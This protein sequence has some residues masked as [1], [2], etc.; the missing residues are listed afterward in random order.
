MTGDVVQIRRDISEQVAA[1]VAST[2]PYLIG[3][4]HHSPVLAA[5]VPALLDGFGPQVVVVEFPADFQS[6]IEH[7][8]D[9]RLVTPVALAGVH[10]DRISFYPF[11][12]FSPE[13]AA[14]RWAAARNIPVIAGDLP[15]ASPARTGSPA[16]ESTGSNRRIEAPT[17]RAGDDAWDRLV[18]IGAPDSSPEQIRTAAIAYGWAIRAATPQIGPSD[19]A[20]E[21]YLRDCIAGR[22]ES[23]VA[24]VIGAFHAPALT[25][26]R[27]EGTPHSGV[28]E[29]APAGAVTT[30]LVPYTFTLLD[31]RSGYPAGIRDPQFQQ[32]VWQ[33]ANDVDALERS[34]A[35]L[36][37]AVCREI[38]RD[39]EPAGPAEAREAI[40]VA[41]DL[42]RLRNLPAPGR[43]E[44]VEA[45]QTVLAGGDVLGRG[46]LVAAAMERILIG[47]RRG[48]LAPGTP[49]SGLLP[50]VD[51]ELRSLR[52][53]NSTSPE[54]KERRLDPL[55]S[56]LDR[57]RT[58]ALARLAVLG[59]HYGDRIDGGVGVGGTDTLTIRTQM[60][61]TPATEAG[62]HAASTAGVT[63]E[64]AATGRLQISR[65][66]EI[67]SGGPTLGESSVGLMEA[68]ECAIAELVDRR[69][70]DLE[71]APVVQLG[72]VVH[73]LSALG[74]IRA[75]IGGVDVVGDLDDRARRVAGQLRA[76]GLRALSGYANSVD[77]DD[78]SAVVGICRAVDR[79][80]DSRRLRVVLDNFRRHG[81]P[82]MGAVAVATSMLLEHVDDE[83]GARMVGSWFD[84]ALDLH[85]R[86]ALRAR[87]RGLLRASGPLLESGSAVL[88]GLCERVEW[89]PDN[90]FVARLPALRGGFDALSPADRSRLLHTIRRRYPDEADRTTSM[91]PAA[92]AVAARADIAGADAARAMGLAVPSTAGSVPDRSTDRSHANTPDSRPTSAFGPLD[93]WRLI[94]GAGRTALPPRAVAYADALDQM[95]GRGRG[96]GSGPSIGTDDAPPTPNVRERAQELAAMFDADVYAEV[97]SEI[98]IRGNPDAAQ[99]LESATVRPSVELLTAMLTLAGGL[100]ES[101]LA[102]LRPVVATVVA[103]LTRALAG[104]LRP[105]LSGINVGRTTTRRTN[106]LDLRATTRANLHTAHDRGDGVLVLAPQRALFRARAARSV[107]WHLVVVTDVSGSM[108][109][110]TVWAALTTAILTGV[111]ALDV[112]FLTFSTEVAD[113]TEHAGDPLSLLLEIQVGGGTNI[114]KALR[115]V[116]QSITVPSRTLV[117]VVSDFEEGGPLGSL[118]GEVRALIDSGVRLLGCASLDESGNARFSADVGGG[119][120]AAGMPVAALSPVRLAEWIGSKIS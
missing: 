15:L 27:D 65:D 46:R 34:I 51:D 106:R 23:R 3:V 70:G 37:V 42:A 111:P 90:D 31:D 69:I 54:R 113:L 58:V 55:R 4:R 44:V 81:S 92:T 77:E 72:D 80:A 30:S 2:R 5:A 7:L 109:A 91:D 99:L 102:R 35:R 52:L 6:W 89:L 13:L 14:I 73:A 101:R 41:G 67:H 94:L 48:A 9:P 11:A 47:D 84:T 20:R 85:G 88:V 74:R 10:D 114:A 24:A 12:D 32:A 117:V 38:R 39:G 26:T 36:I 76:A 64:S 28:G 40:R 59:I 82:M 19:L 75:G 50:A 95:Y 17:G 83:T 57:R 45:L 21:K 25:H 53:P 66:R 49:V 71:R 110:S 68:A 62:L 115:V 100:P 18:E 96:E 8:A 78:V 16:S 103:E 112:R 43:G 119:L 87:L 93:R 108:E 63:L 97:L 61:W 79:D 86:A 105:A 120:A 29:P 1:V 33:S 98:V 56:D 107:D 116:R 60:Q 118:Y 22:T 104:R